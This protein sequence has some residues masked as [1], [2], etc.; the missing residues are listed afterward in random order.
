MDK[1]VNKIL[2]FFMF[3][4][5]SACS[6]EGF[7][8]IPSL[9][10][11]DITFNVG[12]ASV[13]VENDR[14]TRAPI[15]SFSDGDS[16]GVFGYCL[17]WTAPNDP[18]PNY[19]SGPKNWD[20]KKAL[21][22]PNLFYNI[23]VTYNNGTFDYDPLV[24]W[25][26]NQDYL[27]SFFAYYPHNYCFKINT[28]ESSFGAPKVTFSMPFD[29]NDDITE[30]LDD[31]KVPDAMATQTIDVSKSVGSVPLN[32]YH[33]LT[34]LNFQINNYNVIEDENGQMKPGIPV[35]IHSLKLK[36]IF[37]KSINIDFNS[38]Y[39]YPD[40][41]YTGTYTILDSDLTVEGL[42]SSMAGNKTLLLVSNLNKTDISDGY[43]GNIGLEIKYSF[44]GQPVTKEFSRPENF[45]PAGGTIYTAQLNF[46]GEAFVLNFI[47]DNEQKWEDGGDSDITFE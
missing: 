11:D 3:L 39:S 32:F 44:G 26:D 42:T 29:K 16:F 10:D 18:R 22:T 27:Y 40:D 2:G 9:S 36:G 35:V 4:F 13:D 41:T 1:C 12:S 15:E 20:T 23:P 38:G 31:S 21:C 37:Y 33:L 28:T 43:L 25:Y 47:V 30:P 34:G 14:D 7:D 19:A 8:N 17:S 5:L 6:H 24:K 45:L 46:I